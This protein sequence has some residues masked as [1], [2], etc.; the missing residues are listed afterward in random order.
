MLKHIL[1]KCSEIINRDDL[2]KTLKE[3]NSLSEITNES[4]QNDITRMIS[5]YNFVVNNIFEN[6]IKLE[7]NETLRSDDN[8]RI[9][10]SH[11]SLKPVRIISVKN[12]SNSNTLFSIHSTFIST[13]CPNKEFNITYNYTPND[14]CDLEDLTEIGPV[15]TKIIIYG[16]A[17]EFLAS[18]DQFNKSEFW[19]N[20]F[21]FEI[22]KLKTKKER[23]FKSTFLKWK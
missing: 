20:K 18:K 3:V 7:E 19:K 17:S 15:N 2:S 10:Y 13:N 14:L 11:F 4:I 1:I 23:R 6:Y 16:V 8:N 21:L 22:F 5:Y 9:Y 12:S